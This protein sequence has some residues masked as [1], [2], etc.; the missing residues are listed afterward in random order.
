MMDVEGD[1]CRRKQPVEEEAKE[2]S[3]DYAH[4]TYVTEITDIKTVR[5]CPGKAGG[6][7]CRNLI[8]LQ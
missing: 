7:L 1:D 2:S 6:V 3:D 5:Y 8:G 4:I